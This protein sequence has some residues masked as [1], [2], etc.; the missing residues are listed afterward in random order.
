MHILQHSSADGP[1]GEVPLLRGPL[2]PVV[3]ISVLSYKEVN[4][5][6]TVVEKLILKVSWK[7]KFS[8]KG[9]H[10]SLFVK[11]VLIWQKEQVK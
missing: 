6:A 9:S 5:P 3:T 4:Q 2:R 11:M 1:G 7:G 10:L 8:I